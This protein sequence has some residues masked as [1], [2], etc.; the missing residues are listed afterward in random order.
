MV[1]PAVVE[2][3]TT[4]SRLSTLRRLKQYQLRRKVGGPR[5]VSALLL[6]RGRRRCAPYSVRCRGWSDNGSETSVEVKHLVEIGD[7]DGEVSSLGGLV[8]AGLEVECRGQV[9]N[10][11]GV[12]GG[13]PGVELVIGLIGDGVIWSSDLAPV[14]VQVLAERGAGLL[15]AAPDRFGADP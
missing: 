4:R 9:L 7:E 8:D 13:E 5:A 1:E 11:G 10:E 6:V 2:H 12:P 15:E 14:I 3:S